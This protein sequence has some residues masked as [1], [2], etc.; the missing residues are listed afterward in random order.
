MDDIFR[1]AE[2][3]ASA[4][5]ANKLMEDLVG[6][7][8]L[9][10]NMTKSNFMVIGN[11]KSRKSLMKQLSRNPLTLCGENMKEVKVTKYLGD[12]LAPTLEASVHQT[13]LKRI[14]L[15]NHSIYEIRTIIEDSRAST[16]GGINVGYSIWE[17]AVV[18]SLLYNSETWFNIPKKTMKLLNNLFNKFHQTMMRIGTGCLIVNY[19]WQTGS[20]QVEYII[21]QKKLLFCFH[22]A[23]LPLS[24]LG[25]EV[26]DL[27]VLNSLGLV[28]DV[29]EHL[30]KIGINDLTSVNK[31]QWRKTVQKY[32]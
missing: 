7:K 6:K 16:I 27:Q 2:T 9:E 15:A 29:Q 25:R 1:M 18:Q 5:K 23:N 30:T 10:F 17:Q 26:Y 14:G 19:Y 8:S 12:F 4:Q 21:L 3:L 31:Y 22:L 13:V 32:V 20:L 11:K 24:S 28:A